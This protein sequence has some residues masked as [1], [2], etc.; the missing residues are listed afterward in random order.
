MSGASGRRTRDRERRDTMPEDWKARIRAAYGRLRGAVPV[1]LT[2][3]G[4]LRTWQSA[5]AWACAVAGLRPGFARAAV[6]AAKAR[7]T[8]YTGLHSTTTECNSTTSSQSED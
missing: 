1:Q 6:D 2:R 7:F 3:Y 5:T 8:E 4:T